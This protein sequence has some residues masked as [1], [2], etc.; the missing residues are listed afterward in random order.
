MIRH[1]T[2]LALTL[3]LS[4]CADRPAPAQGAEALIYPE[5]H[6]INVDV[7]RH[8]QTAAQNRIRDILAAYLP[9][10]PDTEWAI[11][12]RSQ[13]HA[14]AKK[15]EKL[16]IEDGVSPKRIKRQLSPALDHDIVITIKQYRLITENCPAYQLGLNRE[17]TGCFID[18]L[19]MKHIAAPSRL[20]AKP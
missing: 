2:L 9:A 20:A 8:G 6:S 19:R 1:L 7:K 16:L 10:A 3:M 4:A 12:Y 5:Q 15:T 17:K 14:V 11:S 13:Q 18:T